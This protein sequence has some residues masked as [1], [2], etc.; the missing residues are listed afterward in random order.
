MINPPIE[1][2]LDRVDSKFSLVTLA[3]RRARQVNSYFTAFSGTPFSIS[4]SNASLNANSPQRA[5]QVKEEVEILGGVGVDNPYFDPTAFLPVREPRF[6]TAGVNTL[7]GPSYANLDLGVFRTFA[8]GGAKNIQFRMEIFNLTNTASFN[9]PNT[10]IDTAA[11]G[12]VTSTAS[13]PRQM[14]FALKYDF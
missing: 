2:L 8:L 6:G 5:D 9:A 13:T 11:G 12:R 3:A 1:G 10:T 4:A 7:R 14:Q